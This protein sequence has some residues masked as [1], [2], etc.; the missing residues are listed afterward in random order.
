VT[1]SNQF[2]GAVAAVGTQILIGAPGYSPDAVNQNVGAA[3]LFE[4]DPTRSDFGSL[5]QTIASPGTGTGTGTGPGG[6]FGASVASIIGGYLVAAPQQSGAGFA[7]GAVFEYS[8]AGT[9]E[10]TFHDP[11]ASSPGGFG[12]GLASVGTNVLAGAP[13]D[14]P[15]AA[16]GTPAGAAYLFN[17]DPSSPTFG[18]LR[19]TFAQPGGGGGGF[20]FAVAGTANTAIIGAPLATLGQAGAGAAYV[21]D[22]DPTSPT[23]GL[24]LQALAAPVPNTG[25]GFGAAV[26]SL[27]ASVL[28]GASNFRNPLATTS[29]S[30]TVVEDSPG[31]NI[32]LSSPVTY[33]VE[34]GSRSVLLNATFLDPGTLDPH[35]AT[36]DW[37]DGSAPTTVTIAAGGYAFTAPHAYAH[38]VPN[39]VPITV[40]ISDGD[41]GTALASTFLT[42]RNLAPGPGADLHFTPAAINENDPVTLSGSVVDPGTLD[43]HVLTID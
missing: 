20:G 33:E 41:G 23:F 9:L 43:T 6:H 16:D 10:A 28:V 19:T 3:F 1:T 34:P 38:D 11:N 21:F 39:R 32:S 29:G 26:A 15:D 36:I 14:P 12:M 25:D 2:G 30:E 31:A 13:L 40:T 22:A 27:D 37:G 17:G 18:G 24:A 5:L 8:T 35:T 7:P 4:G 42:V